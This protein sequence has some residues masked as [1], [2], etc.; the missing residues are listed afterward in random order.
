V[1]TKQQRLK[2]VKALFNIVSQNMS[3]DITS[4]PFNWRDHLKVHP[5]A[6]LFPLMS[7][8]DPQALKELAEDIRKNGGLQQPVKL[9]R[10]RKTKDVVL[11]DGRNRLDALS[12]LGL[13]SADDDGELIISNSDGD[14]WDWPL[15]DEETGE[16]DDEDARD[17]VVSLNVHRRH[18]TA[19][20]KRKIIA[21][22]LKLKPE[23]SDR[24]IAKTVNVD[25]KTVAKVRTEMERREEIPHVETRTDS[26][27]R[28][29]PSSKPK[30]ETADE[31]LK[32]LDEAFRKNEELD[33]PE[34]PANYEI[35]FLVRME[36]AHRMSGEVEY[37]GKHMIADATRFKGKLKTDEVVEAVRKLAEAWSTV[38]DKLE[39]ARANRLLEAA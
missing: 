5:A 26:K 21:D 13:L 6:D 17:L 3:N 2:A 9:W 38:A 11:L 16:G 8:T 1:R 33:V 30:S 19:E 10:C 39:Q 22:L 29:Q 12:L 4:A 18:L 28:K 37:L 27:G 25:N 24:A 20:D 31:N 36:D 34:D 23:S 14:G 7:E 32:V 15:F 35:A